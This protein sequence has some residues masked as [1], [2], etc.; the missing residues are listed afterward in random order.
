MKVLTGMLLLIFLV[1][2][3]ADGEP[4]RPM[5]SGSISAGTSGVSVSSA[6]TVSHESFILR[7]GGTKAK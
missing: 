4:L 3:G 7:S 5:I 2:C 6:I 1:G